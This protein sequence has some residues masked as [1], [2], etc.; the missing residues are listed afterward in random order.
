MQRRRATVSIGVVLLLGAV[1]LNGC[2]PSSESRIA[3]WPN[4][5]ARFKENYYTGPNGQPILHGLMFNWDETGSI[6]Q[7]GVWKDGVPWDGVCWIPAAGEG[8]TFKQYDKGTFVKN[9]EGK[10]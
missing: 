7:V 2:G 6:Q 5:E 4:G 1:M 10:R 9:V 8:G 3:Y